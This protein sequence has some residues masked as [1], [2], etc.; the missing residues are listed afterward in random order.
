MPR[1]IAAG[2]SERSCRHLSEVL[3]LH[4][5][6]PFRCCLS[7]GEVRRVAAEEGIKRCSDKRIEETEKRQI[8]KKVLPT[9]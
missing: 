4:G 1:L 9:G 3:A 8:A 5:F 6:A 7:A 2:V